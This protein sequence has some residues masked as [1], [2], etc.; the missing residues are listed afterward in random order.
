[1]ASKSKTWLKHIIISVLA[2]L[3]LLFLTYLVLRNNIHT[4]TP[5]AVYRSAQLAPSRLKRLV[6][7]DHIRTIINLRGSSPGFD[8]YR[9]ELSV[10]RSMGV[11]H[12]DIKLSSTKL[13]RPAQLQRLIH[14][15][16]TAP[17]PIL[18]HCQ[19]GADRTGFAVAMWLLM[20]GHSL[21]EARQAFSLLYFVHRRDSVGKQVV[22]LY[23]AWLKQ[24]HYKTN[25]RHFLQWALSTKLD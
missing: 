9:D 14:L 20:Q 1:M 15:F 19:G 6:H 21:V 13:P 3:M 18:L 5:G 8:W 7:Q 17:K 2:I 25:S 11:A 24:H 16:R 22:P 12:Y 4:V 23:S 10:S